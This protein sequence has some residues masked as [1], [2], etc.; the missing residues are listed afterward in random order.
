MAKLKITYATLSAD[1]EELQSALDQAIETV[2]EGW[3]G[4]E[5]PMWINGQE[6]YTEEKLEDFSPINTGLKLGTFQS[7]DR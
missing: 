2:Q 5:Y 1:N 4:K 6:V 7:G 3:L